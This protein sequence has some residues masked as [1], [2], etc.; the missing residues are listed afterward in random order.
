MNLSCYF[1]TATCEGATWTC[2]T[3]GES[4]CALHSSIT[5]RGLNVECGACA[6]DRISAGAV[7]PLQEAKGDSAH[8][9]SPRCVDLVE[10]AS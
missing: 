2:Q 6:N 4:Y 3:C 5:P 9:P 10:G 7:S 8:R 1:G